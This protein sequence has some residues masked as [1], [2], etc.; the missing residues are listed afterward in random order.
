MTNSTGGILARRTIE[1]AQLDGSTA[2]V[3]F[4][5][6]DLDFDTRGP[7]ALARQLGAD[8]FGLI[9]ASAIAGGPRL[10]LMWIFASPN[11]LEVNPAAEEPNPSI[12]PDLLL[13][14]DRHLGQF[15]LE[16]V[17]PRLDSARAPGHA[18]PGCRTAVAGACLAAAPAGRR[19]S[20][21]RRP[22]ALI[23]RAR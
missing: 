4:S 16:E 3:T 18:R 10:P 14:I 1:V 20:A 22:E 19:G 13:L 21:T 8:A 7:W 5:W 15:F 23:R 6:V 12:A 9:D 17:A 2:P 11:R